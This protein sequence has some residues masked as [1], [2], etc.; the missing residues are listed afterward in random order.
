M[1][2]F[3]PNPLTSPSPLGYHFFTLIHNIN[4]PTF[5]TPPGSPG[6]LRIVDVVYEWPIKKFFD[7]HVVVDQV[8]GVAAHS[9]ERIEAKAGA[10]EAVSSFL[11]RFRPRPSTTTVTT[12][13]AVET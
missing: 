5:L 6:S 3:F 11:L 9:Q 10:T 2:S 4:F 12:Y 7:L 13:R 1:T 8:L